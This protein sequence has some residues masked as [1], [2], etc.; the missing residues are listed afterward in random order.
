MARKAHAVIN[1]WFALFRD[2]LLTPA[3][4]HPV[5]VIVACIA[6]A[7]LFIGALVPLFLD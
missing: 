1:N 3:T 5:A 4:S 2:K 6:M 7:A